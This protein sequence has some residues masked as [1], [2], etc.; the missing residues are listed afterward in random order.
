MGF[1]NNIMLLQNWQV[2]YT[3]NT[4]VTIVSS[5]IG[6][7]NGCNTEAASGGVGGVLA[8]FTTMVKEC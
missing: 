8:S 6:F 2:R 4:S 1:E 7:L 5:G 3:D